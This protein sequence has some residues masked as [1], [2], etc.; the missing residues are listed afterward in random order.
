MT[1]L[2]TFKRRAQRALDAANAATCAAMHPGVDSALI[3]AAEE[4]QKHAHEALADYHAARPTPT[5]R[6]RL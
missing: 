3:R 4:A 1:T 6:C 2:A 5:P